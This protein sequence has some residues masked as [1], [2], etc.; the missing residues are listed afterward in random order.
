MNIN[1][2][3]KHAGL[4]PLFEHS[5]TAVLNQLNEVVQLPDDMTMDD[6]IE[7]FDA[8]RR[9]LAIVNRM[10]DPADRKKWLS[11]VIVNMNKVR[12][13]LTQIL[14]REGLPPDGHPSSRPAKPRPTSMQ[15]DGPSQPIPQ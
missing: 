13:A 12:G 4:S 11:A 6:A 10:K 5:D 15:S 2:I 8:C 1:D 7:R 14:N 3:R 9:A